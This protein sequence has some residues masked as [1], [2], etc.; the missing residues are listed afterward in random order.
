MLATLNFA[1]DDVESF[2]C[3]FGLFSRGTLIGLF[4]RGGGGVFG[5]ANTLVMLGAGET[6]PG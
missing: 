5:G 3:I 1:I 6:F 2:F 4:G